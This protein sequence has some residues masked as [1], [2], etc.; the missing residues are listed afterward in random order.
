MLGEDIGILWGLGEGSDKGG[1]SF[2]VK[3]C[4]SLGSAGGFEERF[5]GVKEVLGGVS[6]CFWSSEEFK[7]GDADQGTNNEKIFSLFFQRGLIKA[8]KEKSRLR[9]RKRSGFMVSCKH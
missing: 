8:A 3:I 6:C 7:S 2:E 4:S 9:R 1:S 5:V